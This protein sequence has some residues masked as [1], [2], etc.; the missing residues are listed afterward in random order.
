MSRLTDEFAGRFEPYFG[1]PAD[2][3]SIDDPDPP[4]QLRRLVGNGSVEVHADLVAF[5]REVGAVWLPDLDNGYFIHSAIRVADGLAGDALEVVDGSGR[6]P[7]LSIGGDGGG[8]TYAME[9]AS[10]R[11]LFL[12]TGEMRDGVYIGHRSEPPRVEAA[13]L[14]RLMRAWEDRLREV[15]VEMIPA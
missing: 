3:N 8:G 7:V 14:E 9:R 2:G 15:V 13:D 6:I 12:P 4:D 5:Y 11:I 1:Y 10:G